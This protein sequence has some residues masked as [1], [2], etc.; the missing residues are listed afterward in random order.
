MIFITNFNNSK[1]INDIKQSYDNYKG[2]NLNFILED[3]SKGNTR[4]S[5]PKTALPGDIV[6][7][8]CANEARH[9]LGM[10]ASNIQN[11]YDSDF[12]QFLDDQKSLYKQYS[13]RILGYGIVQSAPEK[14]EAWWMSEI[15]HLVK[16]TNAIASDDFK[17]FISVSRTNSITSLTD[18]QWERLK[19]VI[20]QKNP[21]TFSNVLPPDKS[22]LDEEFNNAVKKASEKPIEV[23][24]KI[25]EKK[26]SS[27][28]TSM[29]QVKVY[30]RDPTIAAYVKKRANGC[31][32]LCGLPAP[33]KDQNDEPYL[34]C[35][36]IEWLSKDGKDSIN[37]CVALC[38]NCHKRMHILDSEDDIAI[39]KNCV[40]NC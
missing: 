37:N 17:T 28:I 36:H 25:A 24:Q 19:W 5:V 3:F 14:E 31:C 38:P 16:F 26:E 12:I 9:N 30:Y 35:H 1:D 33:F 21:D 10:A 4:W 15:S 34:E 40:S 18:G 32:Q 27:G 13:G 39:L 29:S 2:T 6:L 20:N 7:F 22:I 8:M 23:L 11:N